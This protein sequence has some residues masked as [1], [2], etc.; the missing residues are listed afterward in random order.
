MKMFK[1]ALL[2]FSIIIFYINNTCYGVS[3][4][5]NVAKQNSGNGKAIWFLFIIELIILILLLRYKVD[6]DD[7]IKDKKINRKSSNKNRIN[8]SQDILNKRVINKKNIIEK[9]IEKDNKETVKEVTKKKNKL[10]D[11]TMVFKN[12][13]FTTNDNKKID[14]YNF[15][16]DEDLKEL[17]R[18]IAKAN[19][20]SNKR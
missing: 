20:K 1:K 4:E 3:N 2:A 5:I 12:G 10:D 19:K 16:D 17:E 8:K 7:D 13:L 11:M 15:D 6:K 9:N 14:I 18:T